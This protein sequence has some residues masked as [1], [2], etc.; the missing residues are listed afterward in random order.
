MNQKNL[1]LLIKACDEIVAAK[2]AIANAES[3]IAYIREQAQSQQSAQPTQI[4]QPR[5]SRVK[6]ILK[7][8]RKVTNEG[9]VS[10]FEDISS[11][12][13]TKFSDIPQNLRDITI[14]SLEIAELTGKRHDNILRDIEEQIGEVLGKSSLL[15]FEEI[16]KDA[17]NRGYKSYRLPKREALILI[18]GY[19]VKLRAKII[20]RL[21]YLENQIL[22]KMLTQTPQQNSIDESLKQYEALFVTKYDVQKPCKEYILKSIAEAE[23]KNNAKVKELVSYEYTEKFKKGKTHITSNIGL[24]YDRPIPRQKPV[25]TRGHLPLKAE[26]Q[27]SITAKTES[28]PKARKQ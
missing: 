11:N 9:D 17:R 16:Y 18:S 4:P 5:V 6:D 2:E 26:Y 3:K 19:N 14:S 25:F 10:K 15:K 13:I 12:N 22:E 8:G 23:A 1:D 21:E 20:D 24:A 7:N 27:N 28:K